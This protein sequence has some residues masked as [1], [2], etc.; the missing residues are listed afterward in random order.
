MAEKPTSNVQQYQP[1][2]D[3]GNDQNVENVLVLTGV[4]SE[5]IR[6]KPNQ[7]VARV[8]PPASDTATVKCPPLHTWINKTLCLYQTVSAPGGAVKIEYSEG[9]TD[10]VGDNMTAEGDVVMLFNAQGEIL[11]LV[12]DVTT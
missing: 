7:L 8:I 11:I 12:K 10:A 2:R 5:T 1:P 3:L 4:A 6:L 9:A